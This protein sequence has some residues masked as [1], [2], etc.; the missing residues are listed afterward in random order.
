MPDPT[1]PEDAEP[2]L[3]DGFVITPANADVVDASL[4]LID[5][6]RSRHP[7]TRL[8]GDLLYTNLKGGRWAVPFA[9]RGIE[10]GLAMRSD[11]HTYV[12]INGAWLQH[13]WLHCAAAPMDQR[14]IPI[15]R[16]TPEEWDTFHDQVEGF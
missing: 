4:G 8:L 13:G 14:P 2:L 3:V 1:A 11:N 6:I 5:R 9:Q 15:D 12:D 16:T 7:F 10:Q